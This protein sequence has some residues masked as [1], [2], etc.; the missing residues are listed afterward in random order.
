MK[1]KRVGAS[2]IYV[3]PSN[4]LPGKDGYLFVMGGRTDH[5]VKTKL[6]ERYNIETKQWEDIARMEHAKARPG[7]CYDSAN[8]TIYI[9]FGTD[10]YH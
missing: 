3:P 2:V 8:H 7:C 6:C 5:K 1:V 9:F 10:S 4:L